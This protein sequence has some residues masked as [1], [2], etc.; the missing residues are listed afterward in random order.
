MKWIR[1]M[2]IELFHIRLVSDCRI[3]SLA[4]GKWWLSNLLLNTHHRIAVCESV[5]TLPPHHH[6]TH[7]KGQIV[8]LLLLLVHT[9]NTSG[10]PALSFVSF[11]SCF[12][13]LRLL[14]F[15][16]S[17][18]SMRRLMFDVNILAAQD[19]V[20][21]QLWTILCVNLNW[22]FPWKDMNDGICWETL[23][24][25]SMHWLEFDCKQNRNSFVTLLL[26]FRHQ[27]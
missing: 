25:W 24:R 11:V 7:S 16:I 20:D 26:R 3:Y 12:R 10:S 23:M 6:S 5:S 14:P 1:K 13:L 2:T 19:D 22:Y 4:I 27:K 21:R 8:L 9:V 17:L 18:L 15:G